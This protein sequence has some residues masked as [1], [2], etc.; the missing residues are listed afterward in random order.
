MGKLI[1]K[2]WLSLFIICVGG[3]IV[4][5]LPYIQYSFYGVLQEA[6]GITNV[7]MGNLMTVLGLVSAV[8][9]LLGG[10][11]ADKF[12]VKWLITI[13][14]ALTGL[15]G[16]WFSTFPSYP[17]LM[18]IMLIYG[19]STVF[20]YWPAMIKAVKLLA[21]DGEHGKMFGFREA[22]FGLFA[23]IYSQLGTWLIFKASPDI[24]GVRNIIFYY[25]IIYFVAAIL[26]FIFIPNSSSN[27][28]GNKAKEKVGM[29]ELMQGVRYVCKM[30]AV[31]IIG[32]MVFCAYCVSGPGLGKLV[33]YWT[34]QMG[35]D[36]STAAA[37]S[38][39]R[40]YLL[41]FIAAT[42]GGLLADKIGSAT[43]FLFRTFI[44]LS[45][46]MIIFTLLPVGSNMAVASIVLGFVASFIIYMMRGTYFVPMTEIKIPNKYIGTAAGVISFIGFLPDAFMF[47]VFGNMMGENPGAVEFKS[48]F[49]VCVVLS[50][51]GGLLTIGAQ[52]LIRKQNALLSK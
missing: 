21:S 24:T 4:Y 32:L 23:F 47:T 50:I 26:S 35:V 42:I 36:S 11:L 10:I 49:W 17:Q 9:Y 48:I 18:I 37:L 2:K 15:A 6:F 7:Q 46:A 34:S 40:L 13:S 22:G 28:V 12:N 16:I 25:S 45:V 20:T 3:G 38:S 14:L 51:V 29:A 43:K 44:L 1:S 52:K 31:W 27:D 39:A 8:A 5:I 33:P 30:P 41:P 19:F